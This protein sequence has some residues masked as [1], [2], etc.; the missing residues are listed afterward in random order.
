[1]PVFIGNFVPAL[2]KALTDKSCVKPLNSYKIWP[3]L[4]GTIQAE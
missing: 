4:T 3:C 2:N 1:M